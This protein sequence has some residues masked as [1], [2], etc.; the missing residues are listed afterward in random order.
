MAKP[1]NRTVRAS[2]VLKPWRREVDEVGR[3]PAK[4]PHTSPKEHN[5]EREL[6]KSYIKRWSKLGWKPK[7]DLIIGDVGCSKNR[8]S[9][10]LEQSPCVTA[11]RAAGK[12]LFLSS[13]GRCSDLEEMSRFQGYSLDEDFPGWQ[14]AVKSERQIGSMIGNSLHLPTAGRALLA[15]C[16]AAHLVDPA[17]Q[18]PWA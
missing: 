4:R 17:L 12:S 3:L 10:M 11:R 13:R 2:D 15:L 7:R 8:K 6:A 16:K 18:D 9:S 1:S 5:R 14:Q